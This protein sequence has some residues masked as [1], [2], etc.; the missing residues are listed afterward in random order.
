MIGIAISQAAFEAIAATM[1]FGSLGYETQR[2]E[3]GE[4]HIWLESRIVDRLTALRGKGE[5][6]SGI[7]LRIVAFPTEI[8]TVH[9][10]WQ[11]MEEAHREPTPSKTSG[12]GQR[13][14]EGSKRDNGGINEHCRS[15][16]LPTSRTCGN[17]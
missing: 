6:Y 1:V 12:V 16:L 13:C 10:H 2:T 5:S 14:R 15:M 9:E 4:L 17:G 11:D 8:Q 3:K 7:I